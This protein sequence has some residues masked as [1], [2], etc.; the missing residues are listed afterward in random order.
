MVQVTTRSPFGLDGEC[1]SA[2][3]KSHAYRSAPLS[4]PT[5]GGP[6]WLCNCKSRPS[7]EKMLE[8]GSTR[9]DRGNVLKHP[10]QLLIDMQ[11][12]REFASSIFRR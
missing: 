2:R 9:M 1:L 4:L 11:C 6:A 3:C 10:L 12:D 8:S 7:A 5:V